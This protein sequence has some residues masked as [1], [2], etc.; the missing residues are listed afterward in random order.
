MSRWTH[1]AGIFRVDFLRMGEPGELEALKEN[2]KEI[3]GPIIR[4]GD[5]EEVWSKGTTLPMGSEGSI[6]YNILINPHESSVALAVIPV[7]GDLRDFGTE[8]Q[9]NGIEEWFN[10]VCEQLW[11]RQA[12]LEIQDEWDQNSKILVYKNEN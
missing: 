9:V 11:I 10:S 8:T 4:W 12:I 6:E 7:W 5:D 2:I 3:L 1:V